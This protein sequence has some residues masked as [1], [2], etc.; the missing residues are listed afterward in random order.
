MV[1]RCGRKGDAREVSSIEGPNRFFGYRIFP[2]LKFG[3]RYGKH[4]REE[5]C[6]KLP[7]GLLDCT[8]FW[9]GITR[10]ENLIGDPQHTLQTN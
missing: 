1:T 3:I 10:L 5:E 7:S 4:A 9:V 6:Q 2:Y 8:K